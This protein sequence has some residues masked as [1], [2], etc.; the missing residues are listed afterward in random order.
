[1]AHDNTRSSEE[2]RDM[3][4]PFAVGAGIL[5]VLLLIILSTCTGPKNSNSNGNSDNTSNM[6]KNIKLEIDGNPI[7]KQV[8]EIF[9]VY[10]SDEF[11]GDYWS[12]RIIDMPKN[13]KYR[14]RSRSGA[15]DLIN[16]AG[17]TARLKD[18]EDPSTQSWMFPQGSSNMDLNG[19]TVDGSS[20]GWFDVQFVPL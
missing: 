20:S 6:T 3:V 9:R 12:M 18:H 17:E 10:V 19:K 16:G 14:F 2:S 11:P 13:V 4:R 1:M 15:I 8:Y 7:E 5:C